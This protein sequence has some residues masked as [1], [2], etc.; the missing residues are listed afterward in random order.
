VAPEGRTARPKW[1]APMPPR[2]PRAQ[3]PSESLA[4]ARRAT[5]HAG[6]DERASSSRRLAHGSA[7]LSDGMQQAV[8]TDAH[9]QKRLAKVSTAAV[10]AAHH[11]S[12]TARATATPRAV[13][14]GG[15]IIMRAVWRPQQ[16]LLQPG[17]PA[18]SKARWESLQALRA[19]R[20]RAHRTRLRGLLR[21]H[22]TTPASPA[23]AALP[24][25]ITTARHGPAHRCKSEQAAAAKHDDCVSSAGTGNIH[26]DSNGHGSH[27][28]AAGP[29]RTPLSLPATEIHAGAQDH[30]DSTTILRPSFLPASPHFA[31]VAVSPHAAVYV[32]LN[33]CRRVDVSAPSCSAVQP[34]MVAEP[35]LVHW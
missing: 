19:R 34:N 13:R 21:H 11:F 9:M 6:A 32:V 15:G 7:G 16:Q 17:S 26:A 33:A 8:L 24:G 29:Q 28:K 35:G 5:P 12:S 22:A 2:L 27:S 31:H 3:N 20:A 1:G 25:K 10:S 30:K 14:C 4:T 23:V 18:R